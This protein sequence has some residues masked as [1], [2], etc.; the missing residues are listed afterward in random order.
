MRY[1]LSKQSAK[2]E[3]FFSG[4]II[5]SV[6][7]IWVTYLITKTIGKSEYGILSCSLRNQFFDSNCRLELGSSK[8]NSC[9]LRIYNSHQISHPSIFRSSCFDLITSKLNFRSKS[10]PHNGRLTLI[11][12]KERERGRERRISAHHG[13]FS[14]AYFDRMILFLFTVNYGL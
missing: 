9:H 2:L 4:H 13:E 6:R 1:N 12:E 3:Q 7:L 14:N 5:E 11:E 8:L 10:G